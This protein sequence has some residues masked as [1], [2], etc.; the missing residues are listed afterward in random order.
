VSTDETKD[1]ATV[2]REK[3]RLL[4]GSYWAARN[5]GIS[6]GGRSETLIMALMFVSGEGFTPRFGDLGR[7]VEISGD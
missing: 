4:A 1:L 2:N 7:F 5:P 3:N 6:R